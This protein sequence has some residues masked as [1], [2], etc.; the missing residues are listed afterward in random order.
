MYAG[1]VRFGR[2]LD[3]ASPGQ[4]RAT[5]EIPTW[6]RHRVAAFA[7]DHAS[8]RA[9]GIEIVSRLCEPFV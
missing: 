4:R 3:S 8:I 1:V 9:F 6:I 5:Y 2:R 7:G